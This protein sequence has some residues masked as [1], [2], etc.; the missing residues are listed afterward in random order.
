MTKFDFVPS[1]R[2]CGHRGSARQGTG[3]GTAS[4]AR[5]FSQRP[6]KLPLDMIRRRSLGLA[7]AVRNS[8]NG[9]T[10]KHDMGSLGSADRFALP[11]GV[12]SGSRRQAAGRGRRRKGPTQCLRGTREIAEAFPGRLCGAWSWSGVR[13]WP[14]GGDLCGPAA[15]RGASMV[16]RTDSGMVREIVRPR[17]RGV[18]LSRQEGGGRTGAEGRKR[19]LQGLRRKWPL[20]CATAMA[21][22]A[23]RTLWRPEALRRIPPM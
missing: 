10:R 18:H 16:A 13:E 8:A 6:S 1:G 3:C 20:P 5:S 12:E 7:L 17:C 22:I 23:L 2:G 14:K 11:F 19:F 9:F 4:L 15:A 21:A